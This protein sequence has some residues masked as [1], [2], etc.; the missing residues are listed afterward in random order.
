MKNV[1]H[2]YYEYLVEATRGSSIF[3][4]LPCWRTSLNRNQRQLKHVGQHRRSSVGKYHVFPRVLANYSS[5]D[6]DFNKASTFRD[7]T[8]PVGALD[9]KC[10]EV[11]GKGYRNFSDPNI[12][13]Q[14][15]SKTTRPAMVFYIFYYGSH[16]SSMEIVPYY[17]FRLKPL[18]SLHRNLQ[19]L[20]LS[21][22]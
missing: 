15:S 20:V 10:F 21:I 19:V 8:E 17:L 18:T 4:K 2:F 11:F 22:S 6:L 14:F 1:L 16:N 3:K 12:P 5:E 7:L 9:V 13:M